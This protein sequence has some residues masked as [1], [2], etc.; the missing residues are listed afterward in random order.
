MSGYRFTQYVPPPEKASSDFQKLLKMF[1]QLV[2]ITSGN[3]A[4]ALQWLTELDRQYGLTNEKYGIGD[5]IEQLKRDGYITDETERGEIK[6]QARSEQQLRRSALEEI[7]GKL[8]KARGGEHN[9]VHSGRGDE[10]TTEK[11]DYEFGDTPEQI[12]MTDSLRNAQINHGVDN[13]LMTERDLEVVESEF[14]TQTSTVL[15]IDISHSMI[16]YGEDRITPAKKVAMALAELITKKYP[17]DT[18]DILVFG[19]D[20]WQI[21]IKD[22]PY[23]QVGPY[24]TNTVAGLELAMDLLRR[25]KNPNKQIFMITDG[26]PTCIK[27]GIRYYKNAFGLDEKILARTLNLATQLRKIKIPVTTFMIATDPYL[28]AFV[29]EFTRANNGNA[30]YSNVQGLGNLV[31]EDFKRNR[32]KSW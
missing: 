19:D 32:R 3:V 16:L 20:A 13:F 6:L 4:E 21:E 15:M 1:M 27:Q 31:F 29:R 28:K 24:H 11:R 22:L 23:L 9:T 12:A 2:L 14:K 18:L 30:Y 10:Q 5:F 17:K 26:K 25:R 8:R 7:F